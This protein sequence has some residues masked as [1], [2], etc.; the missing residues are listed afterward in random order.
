MVIGLT[1]GIGSGK[2]SVARLFAELGIRVID[3]DDIS[4]ALSLPPSSVLDEVAVQFGPEFLSADGSLNRAKMRTHVFTNP[5]AREKLEAIFHPQILVQAKTLLA[6]PSRSPYS[7]LVVPLLF[8]KPLFM[9][10][11][12]RCAIV[13][14]TEEQQIMRV[15]ARSKLSREE[16]MAIMAT[17]CTRSHRRERAHDI[18]SN[19]GTPA[20][21]RNQVCRLHH[22]YLQLSDSVQ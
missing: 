5:P 21:L 9:A 1:G 6:A 19:E 17:Q 3:T 18:I 13:D 16:V 15:M 7:I 2:S 8:E 10:L 20:D 11:V 22:R 14:C 12:Q 4:H